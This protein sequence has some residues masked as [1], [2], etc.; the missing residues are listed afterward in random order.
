MDAV[1]VVVLHDFRGAVGN[2][3]AH[4]G[5]GRIQVHPAL[6]LHKVLGVLPRQKGIGVVVRQGGGGLG[7]FHPQGVQPGVELQAQAVGGVN[8]KLQG[9]KAR[10]LAL[11]AGEDVGPGVQRRGVQGVA[12]GPHVDK[13]GVHPLLLG[14]LGNG[15]EVFRKSL[16][17]VLR[18]VQG[19]VGHPHPHQGFLLPGGGGAGPGRWGG[20]AFPGGGLPA[21]EPHPGHGGQQRGPQHQVTVFAQMESSH[22]AFLPGGFLDKGPP[23]VYHP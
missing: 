19:E 1:H 15:L 7:G 12:E 13:Q 23:F 21:K 2:H 9:V 3:G 8:H 11:G 6:P 22:R 5:I 20:A 18:R 16:L 17:G 14:G 10:V 4:G